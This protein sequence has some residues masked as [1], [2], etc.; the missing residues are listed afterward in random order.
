M[1]QGCARGP[2]CDGSSIFF[3]VV[4]HVTSIALMVKLDHI[5][6]SNYSALLSL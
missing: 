1:S 2:A 5:H 4:G 6:L 3:V